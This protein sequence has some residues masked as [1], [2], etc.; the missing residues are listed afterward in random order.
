MTSSSSCPRHSC[1]LTSS[2][3]C[4]FTSPASCQTSCLSLPWLVQLVTRTRDARARESITF[5]LTRSQ[6]RTVATNGSCHFL[7][8]LHSRR[9]GAGERSQVVT[10]FHR[11][12]SLQK[13]RWLVGKSCWLAGYKKWGICPLTAKGGSLLFT[14]RVAS[15]RWS[16]SIN[17]PTTRLVI[18]STRGRIL[19]RR[20]D[21]LQCV[22]RLKT[23]M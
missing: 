17:K 14:F 7:S 22:P 2:D 19:S 20:C 3:F 11:L 16:P 1:Q 5:L 9:M 10:W 21:Q 13:A 8:I 6:Q 4:Q 18:Y 15:A 23:T 12:S